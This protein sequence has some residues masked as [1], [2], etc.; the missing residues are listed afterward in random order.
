[1]SSS[2][3]YV[4]ITLSISLVLGTS[5]IYA[6][7]AITFSDVVVKDQSGINYQRVQS[8]QSAVLDIMKE[9]GFNF[10]EDTVNIPLKPHGAPGV[11]VFDY[12]ND[13]DLDIYVTNGPGMANSLYSSQF[14]ETGKLTF[15]DISNEA[16]VMLTEYDTTGVC[17]GDIDNDG[18]HD[19]MVLGAGV[20]NHLFENTGNGKFKD[21]TQHHISGSDMF[22][23]TCSMGDIN[24]DGLLDIA[25]SNTYDDWGD[26]MPINLFGFEYRHQHNQMLINRGH[27]HFED[28]SD[29]SGITNFAGIS[30]AIALVDYDLDG[31]VDLVTADDQG[32]KPKFERGGYD[33]GYIRIYNNNGE[34]YFS[35][36]TEYANT[37]F[38]GA[39]MGLAFADFNSDGYMDIF[40]SNLGDNLAKN[41]SKVVQ[42]PVLADDW[43]STWFLGSESGVFSKPGVGELKATSFGWGNGA[44]D[45]DNDGDTDIIF[46]GGIDMGTFVDASN[47]GSILKNDGHANFT[48][49]SVALKNSTNHSRR[50]VHGLALADLNHDG[51]TDIVSVSNQNWDENKPLAPLLATADLL[52]SPFDNELYIWPVFRPNN[53][54]NPM[55][56][57]TWNEV[58][59]DNGSLAIEINNAENK[60]GW[61]KV[62]LMGTVGMVKGSKSNRDGIG[63]VVKFTPHHGNTVMEPVLGGASY[64]SQHALTRN[65]GLGTSKKGYIEVIWSGGIRNRLY[66]VKKFQE[67]LFPEI[68][69]S[70][71]DA[72]ISHHQYKKCV[73]KSLYTLYKN[74]VID[75]KQA[76]QFH[77]SAMKAY[78]NEHKHK[79]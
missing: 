62:T 27:N 1:M 49:D 77:R 33:R 20:A 11:A 25:I 22:S 5:S 58:D 39:W 3:K 67:V 56:G 6:N 23:T 43:Q 79:K 8:S 55:E 28:V 40:G 60:H 53:P 44:A 24:N 36:V 37:D 76:H 34:G 45:Y 59:T 4:P 17:F 35:D 73:K 69:C 16:G 31:D 68:P 10:P 75:R 61:V 9:V 65:F 47:P 41:L 21:I 38:A 29:E 48:R 50:T 13:G 66:G 57:F 46:Y 32:G 26:F 71:D 70:F 12:D 52:G 54:L 18:D 63:A 64:S 7:N 78:I 51:F 19:L 2:G 14:K 15:N 72:A 74:D 30:W 42:F